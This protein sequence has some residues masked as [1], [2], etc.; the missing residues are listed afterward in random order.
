VTDLA[1]L[2]LAVDSTQVKTGTAALNG[3]TAAGARAEAASL[4]LGKGSRAAAAEG[5][6]M[7]A[8]AQASARAVMGQ[9]AGFK[10]ATSEARLNTLA[11]RET[12]V[13]ARELSRGNFTR[14]PGSLSLLAQGVGSQGGIGAY[15]SAMAQQFGLIK[16]VQNAE[17]AEAATAA[18]TSAA[19]VEA[20]ARKAAANIMA[21]DTEIALAE[22]QLRVTQGTSAESA[23]QVRLAEA[24]QAV[25]AAAAEAAIAEDALA[26]AMGRSAEAEGRS[27]AATR[28]LIGGSTIGLVGIATVAAVAFGAVKQFQEQVK[29]DGTLTR[30]RDNL[31]LTHAEML[32]LSDGVDKVGDH[33]KSLGDVTVTWGDVFH[34]IWGEVVREANDGAPWSNMKN[35]AVAAFDA[36]LTAWNNVSA[37]ITAGLWT[38]QNLMSHAPGFPPGLLPTA[39][40]GELSLFK[41]FAKAKADNAAA[42]GG[43]K[44]GAIHSAED[45]MDAEA[46]ALKE[47]RRAKNPKKQSDHGLAEALAKLDAEI[48]GQYALAAAYGVSDAAAQ[49]AIAHQKAAEDAIQHHGTADQFY[50]KELQKAVAE[51]ASAQAKGNAAM[52]LEASIRSQLNGQVA[53]GT[54]NA[55]QYNEQLKNQ[56]ALNALNAAL[57]NA[58]AA[59]KQIIRDIIK[60]TIQLQNE[61]IQAQSQLNAL[62][63]IAANDND[64]A[65]MRLE[66]SLLGAS[67]KERAVA[68]AQLEAIQQ[69]KTM[70]GL[71]VGE[72]RDYVKSAMDKAAASVQTPFQQWAASIP[73]TAAAVT[74]ALQS[75]EVH[76]FDSLASGIADVISG[77]KSLGDAFKD[78]AHQIINDII[79][80]TVRMLIFR[81]ISGIFG[82][83]FGGGGGVGPQV[84]GARASGGPVSSGQTYLVGE[85][86]PELF[87]PSSSGNIVPNNRLAANNNQAGPVEVVVR[88]QASPELHAEI[89][90][91][92]SNGIQQAAPIIVRASVETTAKSFGRRP[93]M[94]SR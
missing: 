66:N 88:V 24:H 8:A 73:Q 76:G 50:A 84:A 40:G 25:A 30:Y 67:N 37:G 3:L 46:K 38:I 57:E 33:I 77:T 19:A 39:N 91:R 23:A 81:A 32:K 89:D 56:T 53:A 72:Q 70:P 49:R 42:F 62:N 44:S 87:R 16:K 85:K 14:I 47:D 61:Q 20:A 2:V 59:H 4:G 68:L 36:I 6:A 80:M 18:A 90:Q 55:A 41:N 60:Q 10:V 54:L 63:Q 5:T 94:G 58:D 83:S 15:A 74:E 71:S 1:S 22:A 69:L 12:L 75:I 48:K 31:G 7:A 93:L 29:D 82:G 43:I 27:A 65:R 52:Q 45:R 86:G 26:V 79:Q 51:Q 11:M 28:T 64:I 13:V 17:L 78:I 34:G 21:A 92:V 9:A 35:H